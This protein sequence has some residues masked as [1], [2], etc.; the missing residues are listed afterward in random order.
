[1]FENL[2]IPAKNL[3]ISCGDSPGDKVKLC[4]GHFVNA[5]ILFDKV[6]EKINEV[7]NEKI[8]ISVCGGSGVGKTGIAGIF[9]YYFNANN[10]N[11]YVISGDNYPQRI[12]QYND[13]ERLNVMRKS[14][15]KS[16]INSGEYN[17]ERFDILQ[18]LQLAGNDVN[19]QLIKDYPW[20]GHYIKGAKQGLENYLGTPNEQCFDEFQKVLA[21]FKAQKSEILLRRLGRTETELW[22]DSVDFANTKILIIEWT[23]GNSEFFSGVD[24]QILL[25][26]TPEETKE[27]RRARNRGTEEIDS[28]F[29]ELVLTV[30][31]EKLT[32]NAYKSDI[33]MAK[34]GS[35]LS[36]EE[37]KKV[38]KIK[39]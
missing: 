4:D 27:H 32:K 1:M 31:Q 30:E 15:L 36:Y 18:K 9:A 16:L 10:I 19:P 13:A 22:Y 17:A 33:I 34:D 35:F 11:A 25:N 6:L 7:K 3:D 12:P 21:E 23:H 26:S 29:I 14:A 20:I 8:I 5:N 37:F 2:K 39:E 28:P 38:M 24:V